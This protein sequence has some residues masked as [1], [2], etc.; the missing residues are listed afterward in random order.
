[1]LHHRLYKTLKHSSRTKEHYLSC[2]KVSQVTT[3]ENRNVPLLRPLDIKTVPLLIPPSL[4]SIR[5]W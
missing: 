4:C 2:C 3:C 5:Y 1:M